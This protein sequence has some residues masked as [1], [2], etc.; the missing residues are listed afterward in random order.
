MSLRVFVAGTAVQVLATIARRQ[1]GQSAGSIVVDPDEDE[2]PDDELEEE[3]E[4]ELLLELDEEELELLDELDEELDD[5][6][7]D[8]PLL[9]DDEPPPLEFSDRGQIAHTGWVFTDVSSALQLM[10]LRTRDH[11]AT[12]PVAL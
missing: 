12:A 1:F 4:L 9:L 2:L 10:A 11:A 7:L 3:D 6:E 5:E 8:E